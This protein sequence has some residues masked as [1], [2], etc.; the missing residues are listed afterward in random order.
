VSAGCALGSRNVARSTHLM[1]L[2]S[3]AEPVS[4]VIPH[5]SLSALPDGVFYAVCFAG[6]E[7]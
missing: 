1:G 7:T 6:E 2:A 3:A 5:P 4:Y